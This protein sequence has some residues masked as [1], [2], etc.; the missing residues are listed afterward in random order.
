MQ[1]R[2]EEELLEQLDKAREHDRRAA[3][4][5]QEEPKAEEDAPTQ[6]LPKLRKKSMVLNL[7]PASGTEPSAQGE[8]REEEDA[9][10]TQQLSS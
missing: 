5:A 6:Q 2:A 1:R 4:S 7:K 9:P 3:Q 8:L 10:P